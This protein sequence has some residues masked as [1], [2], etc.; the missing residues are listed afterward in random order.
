MHK[1]A[2]GKVILN[3]F[4]KLKQNKVLY[5][6]LWNETYEMVTVYNWRRGSQSSIIPKLS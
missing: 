3:I 6:T 4:R 2:N 1:S 5:Y